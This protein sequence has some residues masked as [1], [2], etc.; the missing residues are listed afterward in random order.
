[1]PFINVHLC[2][3][4]LKQE[5]SSQVAQILTHLAE[6]KLHKDGHVAAVTVKQFTPDECFIN[7]KPVTNNTF[8]VEIKVTHG[9][10][11]REDKAAFIK[12]AYTE[13]SQLLGNVAKESYIIVTDVP[14]SDWGFGGLTQDVRHTQQ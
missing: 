4:Q 1:M 10:N 6:T 5:T 7:A 9:T 2:Q 11:T 12:A 8:M 13:L 3:T 14:G